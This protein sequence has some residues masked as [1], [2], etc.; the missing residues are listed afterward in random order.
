MSSFLSVRSWEIIGGGTDLHS[1]HH[2]QSAA[3]MLN[4]RTGRKS[5]FVRAYVLL[6]PAVW[7]LIR[8]GEK[9]E[10]GGE[11]KAIKQHRDSTPDR[12]GT[13]RWQFSHW[14][15]CHTE[16]ARHQMPTYRSFSDRIKW[17]LWNVSASFQL[18]GETAA[19][20]RCCGGES[21]PPD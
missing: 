17:E 4:N 11:E 9:R 20:S 19:V 2:V 16:Q 3:L 8:A 1:V 21:N 18:F 14:W 10:D 13:K 7:S 5:M 6:L 15:S 12:E